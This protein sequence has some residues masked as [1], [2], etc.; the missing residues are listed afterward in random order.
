MADCPFYSR[1]DI[2]REII[3]GLYMFDASREKAC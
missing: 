3:D 2:P 1:H